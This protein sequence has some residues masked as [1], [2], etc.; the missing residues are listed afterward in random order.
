MLAKAAAAT[1]KQMAEQN[2]GEIEFIHHHILND[3]GAKQWAPTPSRT[4]YVSSLLSLA[5]AHGYTNVVRV[6]IDGLKACG[7]SVSQRI[8]SIKTTALHTAAGAGQHESLKLLLQHHAAADDVDRRDA[9]GRT[10]LHL[11]AINGQT[12][13]VE[14]LLGAKADINA[15]D[16][17]NK[18]PLFLA[19]WAGQVGVV[20]LLLK[21][22]AAQDVKGGSSTLTP[23]E[24]ATERGHTIVAQALEQAQPPETQTNV[25]PTDREARK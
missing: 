4:T 6:L 15:Q 11:A 10:A 18:T 19:A 13:I 21:K 25:M 17:K 2:A 16:N 8:G 9:S 3:N 12:T 23:L 24:V 22:G 5:A 7:V 1:K 20:Q 14:A